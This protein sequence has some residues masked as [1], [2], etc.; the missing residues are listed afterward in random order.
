MVRRVLL[1]RC[2]SPASHIA[3]PRALLTSCCLRAWQDRSRDC[4]RA[5]PQSMALSW[6]TA[7]DLRDGVRLM[8]VPG[9]SEERG[10]R[11]RAICSVCLLTFLYACVCTGS[12]VHCGAR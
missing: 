11:D 8:G 6:P 7:R 2:A 9:R 1:H 3:C 12:R 10:H 5:S 4:L